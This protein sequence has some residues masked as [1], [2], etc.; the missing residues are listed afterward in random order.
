MMQIALGAQQR[1]YE[2][3]VVHPIQLLDESYRAKG[4]YEV[5][6]RDLA[7][8][9][10]RGRTLAIGFGIGILIGFLLARRRQTRD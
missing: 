8:T 7:A 9:R 6:N 10:K 1:G 3:E 5:P 4:I 2:L